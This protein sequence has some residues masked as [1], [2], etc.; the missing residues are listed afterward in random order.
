MAATADTTAGQGAARGDWRP[1]GPHR[2]G[3]RVRILFSRMLLACGRALLSLRYRV[4]LE[5]LD[6]LQAEAERARERGRGGACPAQPSRLHG[7]G[8]LVYAA[9]RFRP[10]AAGGQPS[11]KPSMAAAAGR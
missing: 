11:D 8:P 1:R 5:G 7:S 2:A 6:I 4:R 9:R 10:A 3:S